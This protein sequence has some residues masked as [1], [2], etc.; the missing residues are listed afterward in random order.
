MKNPTER[1][2][3]DRRTFLTL[4]I[5]GLVVASLPRAL[6]ARRRLV[7]RTVPVMSTLAE[8]RVVYDGS[9]VAPAE[10]A[11]DAALAELF[12][13]DRT[14]TRF[15][16]YSEVGVANLEAVRRPVPIGAATAAVVER[17]LLWAERTGG[18]FD[19]CLGEA[20]ALWDVTH[21]HEPPPA[22][23][24]HR[25]A[26]LGLYRH[27]EL[28]RR[29]GGAS[30]FYHTPEVALDLGGIA[31]GWG[32]D[33]AVA[34]LRARGVRNALVNCGGDLYALGHS[35]R[36]DAWEIGV[37]SPSDPQGIVATLRL[38]DRAVA[39]SGDYRQYFEFHGQRYHH[40]LDPRTGAPRFTREHSVSV[41]AATCVDADAGATTVFGAPREQAGAMLARV[42]ADARLVHSL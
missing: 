7:T 23:E 37:Q 38:S 18:Q 14:M 10:A 15:S 25:F 5:G 21:R 13:V 2:P 4:G 32:V 3:L 6:S 8:I 1:G 26:G 36:G 30:L 31:K 22:G 11:I 9:D 27:L 39:T 28:G 20:C 41:E 29:A 19:P 33:R 16:R 34:A 35:E 40:I 24:V 17:G 42:T 12:A